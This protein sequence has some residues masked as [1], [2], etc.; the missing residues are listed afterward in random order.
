MNMIIGDESPSK[1][2]DEIKNI[3]FNKSADKINALKPT[4]ATSMFDGIVGSEE[5]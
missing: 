4:I 5:E 3:L 1:I 2:S